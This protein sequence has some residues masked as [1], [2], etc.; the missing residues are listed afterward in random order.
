[1]SKSLLPVVAVV[2]L[3]AGGA[4]PAT[5]FE[6]Y[7]VT[8]VAAG[9]TLTVREEPSEGEA[10]SK[11]KAFGSLPADATNVLGTGRSKMVGPQRWSEI[12]FASTLGWVNAKFLKVM[13]DPVDLKGETFQCL[14]T[15][16]FWGVTLSLT[17]G[18]YSDPESKTKLTTDRLQPSTA[19]LF[20]LLY[21]LKDP[22]GRP[23][24]ATITHQNWCIDGMSDYEYAFEVLLSDDENFQQGCCFLKR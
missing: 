10:P 22:K 23:F 24:Q 20:P 15:E 1:M 5:A 16:P 3:I 21:R 17:G 6:T 11:W 7:Q 18:E 12:S 13:G 19:R 4:T 2:L 8:G 14:G 9:D